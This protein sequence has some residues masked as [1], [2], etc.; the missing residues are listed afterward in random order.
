MTPINIVI[1][2]G[3]LVLLGGVVLIV[4]GYR[5]DRKQVP[6]DWSR[7]WHWWRVCTLYAVVGS[8]GI[9]FVTWAAYAGRPGFPVADAGGATFG[10]FVFTIPSL[11][12]RLWTPIFG[13]GLEQRTYFVQSFRSLGCASALAVAG[14]VLILIGGAIV[15]R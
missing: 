3:L 8:L 13:M 12:W 1:A 14:A 15:G 4:V 10:L 9:M 2:Y 6:Y 11:H 7:Y 5:T